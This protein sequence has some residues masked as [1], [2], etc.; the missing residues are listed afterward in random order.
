MNNCYPLSCY[1]VD[2][3]AYVNNGEMVRLPLL[4]TIGMN[5][6]IVSKTNKRAI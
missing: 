6:E 5:I 4:R 1:L 2:F 3:D